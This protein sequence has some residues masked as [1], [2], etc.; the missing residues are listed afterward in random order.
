[1]AAILDL[2]VKYRSAHQ[3][4]ITNEFCNSKNPQNHILHSTVSQTT[5]KLIFKTWPTAAIL[6]LKVK[7]RPAHYNNIKNEFLD[8]KNP[9]N[10][11]LH[12]TVG[13]TTEK[14]IFNK[15]DG[16]HL[17]F[18]GQIQVSSSKQHHK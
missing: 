11:I 12:S 7:Y 10:H 17:G 5:E 14:L 16:S 9:Q 8:P 6:D 2:K 3:N 18:E 15:A 13:Q 4:N 1:M